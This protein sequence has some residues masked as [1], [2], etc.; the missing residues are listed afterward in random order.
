VNAAGYL[1]TIQ[2]AAGTYNERIAMPNN[3]VTIQGAGAEK[4]IVDGTGVG[5]PNDPVFRFTVNPNPGP[6]VTLEDLTVRGGYRGIDAG[7]FVNLTLRRLVIRDNGI[8]S[9]AGV[10]NNASVVTLIE[11]VVRNNTADDPF[12]GCD[13]SGGA[14]GGIA[15]LCGGGSYNVIDSAI[16]NNTA[17]AGAGAAFVNGRH[18]ILNSTFSGNQ[19]TQ[20]NSIGAAIMGFSDYLE[21]T[22]STFANNSTAPNGGAVD[23][24]GPR[25]IRASIFDGNVGGNCL[26][27]D[28]G[29]FVST[30]Y[31]VSSDNSC[32]TMLVGP[33]DLN[34]T[35]AMLGPLQDNGGPTPTH[36][37]LDGS[38][39]IDHVPA[40]LCPAPAADQRGVTRPQQNACDS[41]AFEHVESIAEHFSA[42]ASLVANV[43]PGRSLSAIVAHA[44]HEYGEGETREACGI[45]GELAHDVREL[46]GRRLSAS[47]ATA[48]LNE[49][50][51]LRVALGC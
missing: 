31:S 50:T 20:A 32:A 28:P 9:G 24:F 4:T 48:I 47:Q 21:V 30:G 37:L 29:D 40:T 3:W 16:V 6:S 36:A 5:G 8:G 26:D 12:F 1:D 15:T 44:R 46:S 10:F 38:A 14:G 2:V 39:A 25:Q 11:T 27:G 51:T 7:R 43:G 41:G 22:N 23:F 49:I 18:T 19:T 34:N 33:G 35:G 42:L 17:R 45:L 13:G